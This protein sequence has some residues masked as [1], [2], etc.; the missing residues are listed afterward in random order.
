MPTLT[1]DD[2]HLDASLAVTEPA[3]GPR[4][5]DPVEGPAEVLRLFPYGPE[6]YLL[7]IFRTRFR[8]AGLPT[9]PPIVTTGERERLVVRRTFMLWQVEARDPS[10]TP[11]TEDLDVL[12]CRHDRC[13]LTAYLGHG[14]A[15]LWMT[16]LA[17]QLPDP[18][19]LRLFLDVVEL[20]LAHH[21]Q[22]RA[23]LAPYRHEDGY[24]SHGL[25]TAR[26]YV[27]D[28]MIPARLSKRLSRA[29]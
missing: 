24:A 18:E 4:L 2:L 10:L 20:T 25:W 28:P 15:L 17:I 14:T 21:H 22:V 29:S 3:T 11:P 12:Y 16:P 5:S 19:L 26:Q 6:H 7:A 13:R 1:L 8:H 9:S 27:A 23:S